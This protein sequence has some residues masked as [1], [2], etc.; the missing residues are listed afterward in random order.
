M[1]A[2]GLQGYLVTKSVADELGIT[3]I[4]QIAAD[5]DLTAAF[6][7]DGDGKA[8]IYGCPESWTCDNIITEQICQYG[9][10]EAFTQVQAGYDAMIAEAIAKAD[11]GEAMIIYTWS[12]SAYTAQLRPGDNVYWIGVENETSDVNCAEQ[13]NGEEYVQPDMVAAIGEDQCPSVAD[14]GECRL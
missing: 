3:T 13:E 4:D 6:D 1:P 7:S 5:A 9:W 8:E 12:P 11:A 10:G 14:F 2:A